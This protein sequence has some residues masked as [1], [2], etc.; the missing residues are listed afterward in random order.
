MQFQRDQVLDLYI[1]VINDKF[2]IVIYHKEDDFNF[3]VITY[4]FSKSSV[5]SV[6]CYKTFYWQ[7]IRLY[8]LSNNNSDF[9][10]RAK[11]TYHT[12][13]SLCYD[14][15]ISYDR[16][17]NNFVFIVEKYML[18]VPVYIYIYILPHKYFSLCFH[19]YC[20]NSFYI[21]WGTLYFHSHRRDPYY[22]YLNL[23]VL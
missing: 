10:L 2:V 20:W 9:W 23:D 16:M 19:F 22:L 8:G 5:R 4:P 7:L 6:L 17:K 18:I 12:L 13:N 3:D 21:H 15:D 1:R 11:F 14:Y